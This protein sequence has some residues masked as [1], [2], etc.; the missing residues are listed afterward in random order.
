MT[1]RM[2]LLVAL[3]SLAQWSGAEE[4]ER[5][6]VELGGERFTLEVVDDE[7]SRTQ[8]LMGREAL[9]T[10]EGMLFDFPAGTRPA[11]WMRNMLISL[12]LLFVDEQG[13]L[14]QIFREV[15]PCRAMP[16]E[17]YRAD[18]P[19]RFVIEVPAGT[20]ERLGLNEGD[21][22]QIGTRLST[23]LPLL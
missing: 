1:L 18:R 21:Q 6:E 7:A 11:I 3:V 5:L 19:L 22:L 14:E 20:A 10:N 17:I 4:R 8:G 15:P 13:R 9:G 12:D 23:P 2:L 16:C